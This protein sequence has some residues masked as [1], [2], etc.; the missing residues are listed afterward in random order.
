MPESKKKGSYL[1]NFYEFK[2]SRYKCKN[3]LLL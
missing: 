2:V 3:I 1:S